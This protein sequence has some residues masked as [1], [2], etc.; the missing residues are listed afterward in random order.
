M[1]IVFEKY[2]GAGND[3]V[4]LNN[5]H[6]NELI[7]TKAQIQLLCNRHFGIGADGLI[8]LV[9]CTQSDFE[10][11]YYNADGNLSTM[12]GN[13]GRCAVAFAKKHRLFEGDRTR[14]KAIDGYHAAQFNAEGTVTL[15]MAEVSAVSE[16]DAGF[17][18]NTGSPH[19]VK[20]TS[21]LDDLNVNAQGAAIRY[22]APFSAEGINVNFVTQ[23]DAQQFKIRTYE[24]GVENETLACGTGAVAAA[25]VANQT[26]RTTET[27][28]LLEATG[29][30]LT[31]AFQKNG[32]IYSGITLS[33]SASFVF[34][35]V[36]NF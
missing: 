20:F 31:V 16:R 26:G 13:G 6:T 21:D 3:F 18:V 29:G 1:Q 25:I 11:I 12:C 5:F 19:Y 10:M 17:V 30:L 22:S 7:L 8:C 35:G 24:R 33:G 14:F 36:F 34:E 2:Q 28:L 27:T 9:P 23:Q 32:A 15:E 4:I